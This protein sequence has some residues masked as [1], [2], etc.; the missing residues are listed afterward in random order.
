MK[1][2]EVNKIIVKFFRWIL[3]EKYKKS[4]KV[5]WIRIGKV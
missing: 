2:K 4:Y 1:G 3:I 5:L